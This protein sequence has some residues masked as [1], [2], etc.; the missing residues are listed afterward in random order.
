[1]SASSATTTQA[2]PEPPLPL[3]EYVAGLRTLQ[4]ILQSSVETCTVVEDG[5]SEALVVRREGDPLRFRALFRRTVGQL[6]GTVAAA[7]LAPNPERNRPLVGAVDDAAAGKAAGQCFGR[8]LRWAA[9]EL[10]HAALMR[11]RLG[12]ARG[13][14]AKQLQPYLTRDL[15][16][17]LV[18]TD[19]VGCGADSD[20]ECTVC[21]ADAADSGEDGGGG[22]GGGGVEAAAKVA[23][24]VE[25]NGDGD[26]DGG[27]GGNEKDNEV[28]SDGKDAAVETSDDGDNNNG[29]DE[30]DDADIKAKD[31]AEAAE[32]AAATAALGDGRVTIRHERSAT[33]IGFVFADQS[34]KES[35]GQDANSE[36]SAIDDDSR[37]LVHVTVGGQPHTVLTAALLGLARLRFEAL[38]KQ[39][40]RRRTLA[41]EHAAAIPLIEKAERTL[42]GALDTSGGSSAN[43]PTHVDYLAPRHGSGDSTLT[44]R[45]SFSCFVDTVPM[46]ADERRGAASGVQLTL[47]PPLLVSLAE[48]SNI[49]DCARA[50]CTENTPATATSIATTS[51]TA[52]PGVAAVPATVN[53]S[54]RS[55]DITITEPRL[56]AAIVFAALAQSTFP[57]RA[58][59]TSVESATSSTDNS[60]TVFQDGGCSDI[61]RMLHR[62]MVLLGLNCS[63]CFGMACVYRQRICVELGRVDTF[64][65]FA[66]FD[67]AGRRCAHAQDA[68]ISTIRTLPLG[69]QRRDVARSTERRRHS[70]N[71]RT[72]TASGCFSTVATSVP[73]FVGGPKSWCATGC[74]AFVLFPLIL[75]LTCVS[76]SVSVSVCVVNL[77]DAAD[78]DAAVRL[79]ME[80]A[81]V[82]VEVEPDAKATSF[83]LTRTV[84]FAVTGAATESDETAARINVTVDGE[85]NEPLPKLL[86]LY[87]LRDIAEA[88]NSASSHDSS[89]DN[90]TEPK[91]KRSR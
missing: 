63:L 64:N 26:G 57:F 54:K 5:K 33:T 29:E 21:I 75:I 46:P 69:R 85:E 74:T 16:A 50:I 35:T 40:L 10:R 24:A 12:S 39:L 41:V 67:A 7:V 60:S 77:R 81:R 8:K 6:R 65:R 28:D 13:P 56:V 43:L 2:A 79:C 17:R 80:S 68:R 66:P 23:A 38:L 52:Q 82:I 51:S 83:E 47:H 30:D 4:G 48:Y 14:S 27:G 59:A 91:E 37:V 20:V 76:V 3:R 84:V 31:A 72:V 1:M 87:R 22:G 11:T 25:G 53:D 71:T 73:A 55:S 78:D 36:G 15:V 86:S 18:E 19:A 89:R 9:T 61:A 88:V 70:E 34:P 90:D 62:S 45:H 44:T 42:R 49:L 58:M 32:A